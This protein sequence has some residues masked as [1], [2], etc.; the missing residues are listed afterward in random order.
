LFIWFLLEWS[1]PFGPA[2][3]TRRYAAR[4]SDTKTGALRRHRIARPVRA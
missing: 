2:I 3:W 4:T 1:G